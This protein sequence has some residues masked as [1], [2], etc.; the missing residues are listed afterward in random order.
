MRYV[1]A[2]MLAVLGGAENPKSA[3]IEKILNSVG[4]EAVSE[5]LSQV[6]KQLEGKNIEELIAA[7]R[8]KLS[9]MPVG[10]GVAVAGGAGAA[11][12]AD[13]SAGAAKKEEAKK[14]EKKED[15]ESDDDMG[16]A[17]FE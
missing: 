14:E 2:Y 17:L 12:A 1:A 9:S 16:F 10:G 15:S 5:R 6:V 11:D 3:D 7:G 4:I 13:A 8:E